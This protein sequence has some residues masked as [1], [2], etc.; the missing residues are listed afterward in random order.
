[1]MSRGVRNV[2]I[3][4]G[5]RGCVVAEAGRNKEHV[6]AFTVSAVDTT[7]AGD[8]FNGAFA[9]GQMRGQS[10]KDSALFAAAV[11]AISVTRAGA[12]P[13][14]PTAREVEAFLTERRHSA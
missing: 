6:P 1:L 5:G 7:A 2:L 13:S 8:A 10:A 3:K 14:M 11:A 9:V 4:L 12:Q